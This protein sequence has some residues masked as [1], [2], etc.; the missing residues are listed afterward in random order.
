[1]RA[2]VFKGVGEVAVEDRAVPR[3]QSPNDAI[4]KVQVAALCGSDLHW[5]RGKMNLP[6]GFIPGHEFV[7]VVHE[8][9]SSVKTVKPGDLVVVSREIAIFSDH[10]R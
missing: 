5:Y 1:M 9:G 8:L 10:C 4:L 7:G 6:T 3:I 2:V